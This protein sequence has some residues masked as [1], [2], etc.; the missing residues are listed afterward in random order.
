MRLFLS[1]QVLLWWLLAKHALTPPGVSG[2]P[3]R[4]ATAT[5]PI[6]MNVPVAASTAA[7]STAAASTAA[8]STAAASTAA[9]STAAAPVTTTPVTTTPA[10]TAPAAAAPAVVAPAAVAP[11]M[12]STTAAQPSP[13]PMPN[14]SGGGTSNAFAVMNRAAATDSPTYNF[15][16]PA[17]KFY[18]HCMTKLGGGLPPCFSLDRTTNNAHMNKAR[19]CLNLY[20]AMQTD[21]ER[22][23]MLP[24]SA[25]TSREGRSAE[26][27]AQVEGRRVQI[28]QTLTQ[29]LASK[30]VHDFIQKAER[31]VPPTDLPTSMSVAPIKQAEQ[32]KISTFHSKFHDK[33]TGPLLQHLLKPNREEFQQWRTLGPSGWKTPAEGTRRR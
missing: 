8:A 23:I 31:Q 26:E 1:Q 15:S 16:T 24:P 7:A 21:E 3:M 5:A 6:T 20:K 29:L 13:I 25:S 12:A 22:D 19:T 27:L 11:A 10:V 9:T 2:V 33:T 28:A 18:F 30:L 4:V 17:W 14:V 32:F